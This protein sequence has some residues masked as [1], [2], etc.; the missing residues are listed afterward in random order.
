L[1]NKIEKIIS[2]GQTGADRAALDFALERGIEIGGYVPKGRLAED[3]KIPEKYPNLIETKTAE[4]EERTRFNVI[5]SDATL[6]F[7]Q[8]DLTGGSKLTL[9]LARKFEKPAL[10]VNLSKMSAPDAA[11]RV[12]PWLTETHC[13]ILNIAGPRASEDKNIYEAVYKI[14]SL[15][16]QKR[17]RPAGVPPFMPHDS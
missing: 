8:G 10:H 12:Q 3:G 14:L 6:V 17:T 9:R 15:L 16:L 1:L 11:G 7:S 5:H 4:P 13:K 2:G